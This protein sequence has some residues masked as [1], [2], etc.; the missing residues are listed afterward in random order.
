MSIWPGHEVSV[1]RHIGRR[2]NY[3]FD[4]SVCGCL[5]LFARLA[6]TLLQDEET[7]V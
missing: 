3:V 4:L 6:N 2:R 5:M 7:G 1:A